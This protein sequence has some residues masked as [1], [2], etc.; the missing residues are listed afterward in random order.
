MTTLDVTSLRAIMYNYER[1]AKLADDTW[2]LLAEDVATGMEPVRLRSGSF[3]PVSARAH[4]A[5][6]AYKVNRRT[7]LSET[8]EMPVI[9]NNETTLVH[10][11]RVKLIHRHYLSM[12]RKQKR[13]IQRAL[14]A[15]STAT[16]G[17]GETPPCV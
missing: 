17:L 9:T 7:V 2:R 10:L 1:M 4:K 11:H 8:H 5:A 14:R 12:I 16:N 6:R 3:K 13:L 15:H